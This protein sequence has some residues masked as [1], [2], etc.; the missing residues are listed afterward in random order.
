[1]AGPQ[2][3]EGHR[4]PDLAQAWLP[5]PQRGRL[6]ARRWT[7]PVV[8]KQLGTE[9][10]AGGCQQEEGEGWGHAGLEVRLGGRL[11]QGVRGRNGVGVV[12]SA[13]KWQGSSMAARTVAGSSRLPP[14]P[15]PWHSLDIQAVTS[16]LL[17]GWNGKGWGSPRGGDRH[18]LW[19]CPCQLIPKGP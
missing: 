17:G 14:R 2:R 5:G 10:Q 7:R 11:R 8:L 9:A 1:M 16:Q 6:K 4:D 19:P 12:P 3:Q 18:C 13:Q 15:V